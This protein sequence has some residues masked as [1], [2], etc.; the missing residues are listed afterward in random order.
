MRCL[1]HSESQKAIWHGTTSVVATDGQGLEFKMKRV[2]TAA[3]L[4]LSLLVA[5]VC[6]G[7]SAAA[8]PV[9]A[10]VIIGSAPPASVM[11]YPK[12]TITKVEPGQTY[13]PPATDYWSGPLALDPATLEYARGS[14]RFA[15]ASNLGL[16][17]MPPSRPDFG[18]RDLPF[19]ASCHQEGPLSDQ[20]VLAFKLLKEKAKPLG[21]GVAWFYDYD[22]LANDVVV[23]PPYVSAFSQAA[24]IHALLFGDCKMGNRA[25]LTL[26]IKAANGLLIPVSQGG[27][28]NGKWFEEMPAPE[29]WMPYILNGHL[30]SVVV[31]Y[32]LAEELKQTADAANA[33]K[34]RNAADE[35]VAEFDSY[36]LD[37]DSGYWTRYD[38]RPRSVA[39]YAEV[40][41]DPSTVVTRIEARSGSDVW[42]LCDTGCDQKLQQQRNGQSYRFA[43]NLPS[44]REYRPG[45]TV[46]IV[47]AY[48]GPAPVIYTGV[49]R[50]DRA[51]VWKTGQG[52]NVQI[53]IADKGWSNLNQQYAQ[54]HAFL[55]GEIYERTKQP[56]HYVLAARWAN[57][58]KTYEAANTEQREQDIPFVPT[59]DEAAD[60]QIAKCL[61]GD[62]R[63]ANGQRLASCGLAGMK[64][65]I[66]L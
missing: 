15:N 5:S 47:T 29:G 8:E 45:E 4:G 40:H 28:R 26:A 23:H 53:P 11:S 27:V 37:F 52:G 31:L 43:A 13:T 1:W 24:N 49:S 30:Y 22:A 25:N 21:D 10:H 50:P 34:F 32:E 54:W 33:Q 64:A 55:M 19:P 2:F 62:P 61:G 56:R 39:I 36:A 17:A 20:Q 65:R 48:S 46:Q 44:L 6:G 18:Q 41:T 3:A 38:L 60:R 59:W 12:A 16:T 42:S 7:G 66:G 51:E 58:V 14:L 35:G 63:K 57:Y 9:S